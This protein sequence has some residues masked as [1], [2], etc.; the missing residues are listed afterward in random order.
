MRGLK[1]FILNNT[2]FTLVKVLFISPIP[3]HGSLVLHLWVCR[4]RSC[5]RTPINNPSG[6]QLGQS[7]AADL[8]LL[9]YPIT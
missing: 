3:A 8:P 9:L 6:E 1:L 7:S 5:L 2:R 4:Q